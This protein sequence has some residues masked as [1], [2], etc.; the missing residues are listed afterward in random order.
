[1]RAELL[2]RKEMFEKMDI[3]GQVNCL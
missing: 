2:C 3:I 1:M